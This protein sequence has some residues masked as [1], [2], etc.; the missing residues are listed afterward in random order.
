MYGRSY[1]GELPKNLN[2]Q[3][4]YNQVNEIPDQ[5]SIYKNVSKL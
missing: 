2:G 3:V 1:K 5:R 4:S